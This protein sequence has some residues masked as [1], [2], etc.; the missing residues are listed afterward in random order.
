MIWLIVLGLYGRMLWHGLR[1]SK[2]T[3]DWRSR[4][5]LLGCLGSLVGF[6]V[7]GLVH[8]NLGDQEVAMVFF[9]L[10]ALGVKLAQLPPP[11]ELLIANSPILASRAD[12]V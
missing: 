7:S 8:Y 6:F 12:V 11:D 9:I 10:M 5:I 3:S 4:G 1:R 2:G